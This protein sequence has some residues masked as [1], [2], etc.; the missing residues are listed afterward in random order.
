MSFAM[1]TPGMTDF[2]AGQ[3]SRSRF[4]R[5]AGD[6]NTGINDAMTSGNQ[7]LANVANANA[8]GY[9][10]ENQPEQNILNQARTTLGL[11]QTGNQ[12][13][14]AAFQTEFNNCRA[15]GFA[16][17][18]CKELYRSA[19]GQQAPQQQTQTGMTSDYGVNA[20]YSLGGGPMTSFLGLNPG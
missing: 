5:F 15:T 16:S 4:Q 12:Q 17:D 9:Q 1:I 2:A 20:N 19:T 13:F 8:L 18:R 3:G 7:T 14:G 11:Q 6:W 10:I